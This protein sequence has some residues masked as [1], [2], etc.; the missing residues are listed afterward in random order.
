MKRKKKRRGSREREERAER[1]ELRRNSAV[2]RE[3]Y[4]SAVQLQTL[5][6]VLSFLRKLQGG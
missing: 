5:G 3:R 6:G 1:A 2:L 4:D